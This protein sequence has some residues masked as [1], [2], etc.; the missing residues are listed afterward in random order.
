MYSKV[1]CSSS[2]Y[3]TELYTESDCNPKSVEISISNPIDDVCLWDEYRQIIQCPHWNPSNNPNDPMYPTTVPIPSMPWTDPPTTAMAT[4]D[5]MD[6]RHVNINGVARRIDV[7]NIAPYKGQQWSYQ[8]ECILNEDGHYGVTQNWYRNAQCQGIQTQTGGGG[9]AASNSNSNPVSYAF[10]VDVTPQI[11]SLNC[12][13]SKMCTGNVLEIQTFDATN[14]TENED[15]VHSESIV[16]HCFVDD[17]NESIRIECDSDTGGYTLS[18]F[19]DSLCSPE[20]LRSSKAFPERI[21]KPDTK[22]MEVVL[23]CGLDEQQTETTEDPDEG[24]HG[25]DIVPVVDCDYFYDGLVGVPM[26]LCEMYVMGGTTTSVM[27]QCD[28]KHEK[29]SCVLIVEDVW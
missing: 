13:S 10:S 15:V 27:Y 24:S 21:C 3:L 2:I 1:T 18:H 4:V 20:Y 5:T 14:C 8:Y 25:M 11:T 22:Q 6:C 17:Y 23:G 29:V 19:M 12:Q 16:D 26:G 28:A 7:C 9:T